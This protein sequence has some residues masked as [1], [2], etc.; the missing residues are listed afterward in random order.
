MRYD[1][2]RTSRVSLR[3]WR[4]VFVLL[5]IALLVVTA[6]RYILLDNPSLDKSVANSAV[7]RLN[8]ELSQLRWQW[9][10]QGRPKHMSYKNADANSITLH[11]TA[12]GLPNAF[13]D[14]VNVQVCA[15]FLSIFI[16]TEALSKMG[17]VSTTYLSNL[18]SESGQK[19]VGKLCVFELGTRQ[20]AYDEQRAKFFELK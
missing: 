9:Q 20:I 1:R 19:A 13:N 8:K 7:F 18:P 16:D 2:A 10:H 6:I 12:T 11:M 5:V 14:G 17:K 15:E 4:Y 3:L